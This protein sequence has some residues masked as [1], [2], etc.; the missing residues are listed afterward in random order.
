M[1]AKPA[2][3]ESSVNWLTNG[4]TTK[5][6]FYGENLA[7]KEITVKAPLTVKLLGIKPTDEK[8][9]TKGVQTAEVE[10]TIPDSCPPESFDL[11]F[12]H[13]GKDSNAVTKICVVE[14]ATTEVPIKK[15]CHRFP[16]AMPLPE[17][18]LGTSV[19]I[20]GVLEGDNPCIILLPAKRGESWEFTLTSSRAGAEIEEVM[21]V[22]DSKRR[23]LMLITGRKTVDKK[24]TF[25]AP[26]DGQYYVEWMDTV[27]RG[28]PKTYFRLLVKRK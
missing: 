8:D 4:Q 21:R 1:Q 16:E 20:S 6:L 13:E 3:K 15:P 24:L 14:K 27:G 26:S 5:V 9:K 17:T 10:V 12:V 2:I 18:P 7:P 22:R 23:P 25:R 28:G 11:T 19:A